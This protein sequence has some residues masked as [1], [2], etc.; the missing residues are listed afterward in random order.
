MQ[1]SHSI[2]NSNL[3]H[4]GIYVYANGKIMIHLT[5]DYRSDNECSKPSEYLRYY[6]TFQGLS[7]RE[8]SERVGIVPATLVQYESDKHPIKYT[9]AILL[10]SELGIDLKR[11]LDEYTS[12]LDYP[13]NEFFKKIRNEFSMTQEQ[14]ASE[15]GVSQNAYSAWE[16]GSRTPRRQEYKKIVVALEKRKVDISRCSRIYNA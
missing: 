7:T 1:V 15:I 14:I 9:T 2:C 12:F 4:T 6:R 8:L 3:N 13:Y 11:L 16:R 10:A 5:Y